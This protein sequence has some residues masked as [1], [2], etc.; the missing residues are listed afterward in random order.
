MKC[1]EA[2]QHVKAQC[3]LWM[4][5]KALKP[6]LWQMRLYWHLQKLGS[7]LRRFWNRSLKRFQLHREIQMPR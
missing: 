5:H 4:L 2:L 7:E 3:L 1:P 6:K